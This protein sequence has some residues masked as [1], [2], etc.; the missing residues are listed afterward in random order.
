MESK[1]LLKHLEK[2]INIKTSGKT[3]DEVLAKAI[4]L[5]RKQV[6]KEVDG[7]ILRMEPLEVYVLNDEKKVEI[8]KFLFFF[9]PREKVQYDMEFK[10]KVLISYVNTLK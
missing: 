6:Y 3:K 10:I 8:E 2:E 4:G 1:Q 5:L 9:M 7:L